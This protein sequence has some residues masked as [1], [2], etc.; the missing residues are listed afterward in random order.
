MSGDCAPRVPFRGLPILGILLFSLCWAVFS[1]GGDRLGTVAAA[2]SEE[3]LQTVSGILAML[4]VTTG[5]G[6]LKTDL[7]KPV[8]FDFNRPDLFTGLSIGNRVAI[9]LDKEGR[10]VKAIEALP[11]EVHEPPPPPV[12]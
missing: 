4:D 7:G 12:Q 3:P 6:M 9:Q 10:A 8:F 11:A 5:K 1:H 2:N